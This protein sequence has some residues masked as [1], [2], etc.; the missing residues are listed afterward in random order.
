MG[1][2]VFVLNFIDKDAMLPMAFCYTLEE[3]Q[4]LVKDAYESE[5]KYWVLRRGEA[6]WEVWR[7][8]EGRI[9]AHFMLE[10]TEQPLFLAPVY[11]ARRE[12]VA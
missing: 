3:A 7:Y 1:Q 5:S 11:H 2:K 4:E 12:A 9:D 6:K 8:N 10:V